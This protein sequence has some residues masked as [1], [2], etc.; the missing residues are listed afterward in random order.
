L[1]KD[2]TPAQPPSGGVFENQTA[3]S[4]DEH[5]R[6]HKQGKE[7]AVCASLRRSLGCRDLISRE[8]RRHPILRI[9]S[10]IDSGTARQP[11]FA[12]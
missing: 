8:D 7:H 9:D 3:D 5:E 2:L 11:S 1:I 6:T 4:H 12:T 10:C